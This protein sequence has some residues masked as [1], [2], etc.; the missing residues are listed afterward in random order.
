MAPTITQDEPGGI[1]FTANMK[2]GDRVWL[3]LG[4][5]SLYIGQNPEGV[6][7]DVYER[8]KESESPIDSIVLFDEGEA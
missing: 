5:W 4:P 3:S 7:I 8:G 1:D 2:E 6:S